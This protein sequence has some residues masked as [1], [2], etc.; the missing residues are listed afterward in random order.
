M[1][2]VSEP[3]AD[4]IQGALRSISEI[5]AEELEAHFKRVQAE[6]EA[7]VAN[8]IFLGVGV[9]LIRYADGSVEVRPHADVPCGVIYEF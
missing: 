9:L 3:S 2:D 5:I 1:R 6:I 4:E 7:A 8:A